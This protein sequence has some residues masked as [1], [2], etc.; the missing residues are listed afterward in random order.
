MRT[1]WGWLTAAADQAEYTAHRHYKL[2]A[3]AGR[4]A[5]SAAVSPAQAAAV[6]LAVAAVTTSGSTGQT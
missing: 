4:V 2:Q 3:V 6:A 5:A 1:H